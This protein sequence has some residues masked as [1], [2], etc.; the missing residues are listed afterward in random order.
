MKYGKVFIFVT[1]FAGL[2]FG[3]SKQTDS[4][5]YA[6]YFKEIKEATRKFQSLWGKDLYSAILLVNPKTREV[7]ANEPDSGGLLKRAGKIYSGS[8]PEN[9]NTANTAMTWNGKDWAMI[10]LPLP[11]D[12]FDRLD[13]IAHEL[14]HKAQPSLGFKLNNIDNNH[15]NDKNG[16]IY[17]RLELEALKQAVMAPKSKLMRHLQDAFVF[18]AYRHELYPN[19]AK[20]E[21][22]LELHEGLAEF[23]G[24]IV[25]GQRGKQAASHFAE[26]ITKFLSNPT[27][28]RSF[29]YQTTPI[30]GYL[31]RN[32]RKSW[33]RQIDVDSDLTKYF[34]KEFGISLPANLRFASEQIADLYNGKQIFAEETRRDE[35]SK[36]RIAEFKRKFV[37][38]PHFEIIFEKMSVS[39]DPGNVV[40]LEEKGTVYPNIRVTDNWGILTVENGALMSPTWDKISI[41]IPTTIEEKKIMGDGWTLDLVTG[42][43]VEK[44]EASGNYKLKK[45]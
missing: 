16:R 9:I 27:F 10:T 18:R 11:D 42:Y 21:N 20:T 7:F 33:N 17:L 3:Q 14:F 13:L 2:A 43:F 24:F 30:Y 8:L 5:K 45:K 12:K 31:L 28:V 41:S 32:R 40:P 1:L 29:A 23:T 15:L 25:S 38:E 19:A 36:R 34:Q 6:E 39:F 22:Q 37:D 35:E 44:D 26:S 4:S